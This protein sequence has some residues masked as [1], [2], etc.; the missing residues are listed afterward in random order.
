[1]AHVLSGASG[2]RVVTAPDRQSSYHARN[3]GAASGRG[4]WLVFLDA[5]YDFS[6]LIRDGA[7][8]NVEQKLRQLPLVWKRKEGVRPAFRRRGRRLPSR[9]R[10]STSP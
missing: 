2:A 8:S 7:V 9:S 10:P 1:M 5:V 6:S 3:R 4:P